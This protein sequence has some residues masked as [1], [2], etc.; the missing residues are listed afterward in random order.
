MSMSGGAA[1]HRAV[2][3]SWFATR[4]VCRCACTQRLLTIPAQHTAD[5]RMDTCHVQTKLAF[6]A[7]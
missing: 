1:M 3:I 4:E 5:G 6:T 2:Y 7:C